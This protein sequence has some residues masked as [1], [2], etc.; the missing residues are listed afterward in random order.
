MCQIADL[1]DRIIRKWREELQDNP[2]KYYPSVYHYLNTNC[3]ILFVGLNPSAPNSQEIPS[4]DDKVPI[5]KI[6]N[7]EQRM[8]HGNGSS[9]EGQYKRYFSIFNKIEKQIDVS[10]EHIDLLHLRHTT[11][12]D[13]E[14]Y[15]SA[16]PEGL[17]FEIE[18][19]K[20]VL[21]LFKTK[22]VFVNNKT[23]SNLIKQHLNLSY[24]SQNDWYEYN[25]ENQPKIFILESMLTR[26]QSL[27]HEERINKQLPRL[28]NALNSNNN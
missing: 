17:Q 19:F 24:N 1:N 15:F 21:K 16:N 22:V 20:D 3:D 23:A 11:Q 18:L 7:R 28:R 2:T 14:Q 4:N 12:K 27:S 9:R 13:I 5:E 10:W 8:I 25:L 26:I 6:R